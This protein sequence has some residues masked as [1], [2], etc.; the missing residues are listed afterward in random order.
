MLA[1]GVILQD[2]ADQFLRVPYPTSMFRRYF[3]EKMLGEWQESWSSTEKGRHTYSIL[4]KI[5]PTF[6]SPNVIVTYFIS[7]HGA[8]PTFLQKIK[9]REDDNCNCGQR[10]DPK[11]YIFSNCPLVP[12][13]F[14]FD[15]NKTLR[16]NM[17]EVLLKPGNYNRLR[18]NYNKLNELYSFIKYR[19]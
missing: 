17:L 7:G 9:K 3:R 11:H 13:R 14:N 10:G 2:K 8:F 1:K 6:V 5:D 4:N 12:H 16:Q 19:F 15:K 18:E